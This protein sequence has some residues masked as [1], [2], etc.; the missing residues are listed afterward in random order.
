MVAIHLKR[1]VQKIESVLINAHQ[2][3]QLP[4]IA[5]LQDQPVILN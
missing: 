3:Q 5:Q 1:S 2:E 4:L